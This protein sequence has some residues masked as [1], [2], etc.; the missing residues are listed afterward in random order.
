[1]ESEKKRESYGSSNSDSIATTT[2]FITPIFDF[3]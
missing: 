3:R 2:L 1:M